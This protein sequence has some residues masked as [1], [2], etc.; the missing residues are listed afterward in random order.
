MTRD[1]RRTEPARGPATRRVA[2]WALVGIGAA[3][4]GGAAKPGGTAGSSGNGGAGAGTSGAAGTVGAAGATTSGAAGATGGASVGGS[5]GTTS[6]TPDGSATDGAAGAGP[7]TDA[8]SEMGAGGA[9]ACPPGAL[10]CDDFE[11]YATAADL[12][13]AWTVTTTTATLVVDATKPHA[14]GKALHMSS[15]GGTPVGVI[16]KQGAPLFPIAGNVMYGRMMMWLTKAPTGAV[17]WNNVQSAGFLPGSTQW[18]KYGWGGMYGTILAGYTIRTNAT[19]TQAVI[20]CSKPSRMALPEKAW[21]CLEWEFDGAGNQMHLWLDGA[22]LADAD[23][24]KTGTACVT[25]KPPN[26][27]WT[28]PTFAN[29]TLGWMQ[30]Q[31]SSTPIEL[32]MDDVVVGTQRVGCP[33]P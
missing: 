15:P 12:A 25:P 17:H 28:A 4:C 11:S 8:A 7:T 32:W 14:G 21:T 6:P 22:L 3:A 10:V 2:L 30:Y 13:A 26:D 29:L 1:H 16:I 20:D 5:G 9:G 24:I 27:T 18:G 19:D 33:S 23:I 31:Q